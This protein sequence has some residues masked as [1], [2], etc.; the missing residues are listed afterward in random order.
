MATCLAEKMFRNYNSSLG[1]QHTVNHHSLCWTVFSTAYYVVIQ[2][3]FDC[4]L[5]VNSSLLVNLAFTHVFRCVYAS[6]ALRRVYNELC[7]LPE[8]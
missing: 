2:P 6:A 7:A 5:F 1:R 4:N 8:G 3:Y